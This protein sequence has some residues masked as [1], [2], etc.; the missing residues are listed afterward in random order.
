MAPPASPQKAREGAG[1][2]EFELE[3]ER[4]AM[5]AF[6]DA[7]AVQLQAF[8]MQW[9]SELGQKA[10]ETKKAPAEKNGKDKDG[11]YVNAA[12][13][14]A[15]VDPGVLVSTDG[16][17]PGA[18]SSSSKDEDMR[19]ELISMFEDA[20]KMIHEGKVAQG[21]LCHGESGGLQ[22]GCGP[23]GLVSTYK[24]RGLAMK[25]ERRFERA[26]KQGIFT[27]D[28][29]R[30]YGEAKG[31]LFQDF[32]DSGGETW[33]DVIMLES[34]RVS[35]EESQNEEFEPLDRQTILDCNHQDADFTDSVR[36]AIKKCRRSGQTVGF[37]FVFNLRVRQFLFS[38]A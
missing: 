18:G 22:K 15:R 19:S 9:R 27:A 37:L 31:D 25:F 14:G 26:M 38:Q 3:L 13:V 10:K 33:E 12:D 30:R 23:Y 17:A 7:Q 5:N 1:D 36:R 2:E 6:L 29:V 21:S 34:R 35:F 4:K 20:K 28:H 11:D 24:Q 8:R 32:A 16:Q